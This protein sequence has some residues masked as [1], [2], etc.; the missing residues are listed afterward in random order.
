[1]ENVLRASRETVCENS[2]Q[3]LGNDE[4]HDWKLLKF[5]GGDWNLWE[6]M[7]L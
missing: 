6:I 7:H 4:Q 1:M 5:V 2:G 3:S